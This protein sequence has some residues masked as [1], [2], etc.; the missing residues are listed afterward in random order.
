M[1]AATASGQQTT[2]S[3]QNSSNFSIVPSNQ[4]YADR[5]KKVPAEVPSIR[6]RHSR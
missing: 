5:P 4:F 2:R 1:T 3:K 6:P